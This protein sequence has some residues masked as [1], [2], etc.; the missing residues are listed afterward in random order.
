[1]QKGKAAMKKERADKCNCE[2][3]ES[4]FSEDGLL[5]W[6]DNCG[7][8]IHDHHQRKWGQPHPQL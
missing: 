2:K 1:L 5:E 6:C 3:P 7:K 4:G 8:L